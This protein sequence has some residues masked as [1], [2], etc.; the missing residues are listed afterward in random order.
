M[1]TILALAIVCIM[2][3]VGSAA[4]ATITFASGDGL[5]EDNFVGPNMT[6]APHPAWE[7]NRTG[8]GSWISFANTGDA[9]TVLDNVLDFSDLPSI[10]FFERVTVGTGSILNAVLNV[11]ADDTARILINGTI[12]QSPNPVQ[13][14]ACA[15]GSLGCQPG[16]GIS[17]NIASFLHAGENQLVFQVFQRGGGPAGLMYDGSV[18]TLGAPEPAT[19]GMMTTA[20]LG[21]LVFAFRKRRP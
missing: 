21:G 15:A 12:V 13:D 20:A 17:A 8:G 10:V 9:G 6:I 3:A 1:T 4:A 11:W 16:E 5:N 19:F 7:G 2:S 18:T 14:G